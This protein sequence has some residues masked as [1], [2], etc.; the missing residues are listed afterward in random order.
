M[1]G[2]QPD[3]YLWSLDG[4]QGSWGFIFCERIMIKALMDLHMV[5]TS[6]YVSEEQEQWSGW[7]SEELAARTVCTRVIN[8]SK[9]MT[10]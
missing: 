8:S 5:K 4:I 6:R 9:Y 10:L 1:I 2:V 7:S 3:V